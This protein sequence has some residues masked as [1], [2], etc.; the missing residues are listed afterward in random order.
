[1]PRENEQEAYK[2]VN[3]QE[4]GSVGISIPTGDN[5]L[6]LSNDSEDNSDNSRS[7]QHRRCRCSSCF[8]PPF[9]VPFTNILVQIALG[10]CCILE[11]GVW[12]NGDSGCGGVGSCQN[13]VQ[14]IRC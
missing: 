6:P 1:M 11:W 9:Q 12:D 7:K 2:L 8:H 10:V 5:I 4:T 3:M 13:Q 14:R